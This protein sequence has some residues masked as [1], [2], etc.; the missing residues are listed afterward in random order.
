MAVRP[1]YY[2]SD[3]P[4]FLIAEDTEFTFHPGFSPSQKRE[5]VRSL[6]GA[7][8][9]RHPDMKVLEVSRRS[10]SDIGTRLSAFNLRYTTGSGERVPVECVFQSSKV[11]RNGNRY[12]ALLHALPGDAKTF[13][14]RKAAENGELLKFTLEGTDYPLVPPTSFYDWV[15]LSALRE[16]SAL[17]SEILG[18]GYEAFTDIEFNPL[19]SINCQARTVATFVMLSRRGLL[20][21][22]LRDWGT[23]VRTV[24]P[25]QKDAGE[26][27][28]QRSISD[29][30]QVD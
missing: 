18:G 25:E 6:H 17:C 23:F 21:D 24:Y 26:G 15:Y 12:P 19:K 4:P 7:F 1:V 16:D 22:C 30:F 2:V 3:A 10:E 20:D 11:F 8:A 9:A 29:F 28:K 14:S 27:R 13:M 5:S